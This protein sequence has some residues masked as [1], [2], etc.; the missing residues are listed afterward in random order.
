MT[1][2]ASRMTLVVRNP[3]HLMHGCTA[4]RQFDH[5]GGSIGST[6]CDWLLD[7]R[8]HAIHPLHCEIRLVEG[9]FCV[10]DLC[11]QTRLNGHDLA[12]GR[13]TTVKLNDG[14]SLHVGA[15]TLNV[16]LQQDR[17]GTDDLAH[18]YLS[19]HA[20]S[21]LF[22]ESRCPLE[23]LLEGHQ[24]VPEPDADT[25]AHSPEFER[26]STPLGLHEQ[27]DPL[28]ALDATQP[29]CAP[30]E[31]TLATFEHAPHVPPISCR[32]TAG[33]APMTPQPVSPVPPSARHPVVVARTLTLILACLLLGGCTMLGKLGHVIMNPSTPVGGPDDQPSL[34]ALS[35]YATNT[36]NPNAGSVRNI[37][38]G[39]PE[40]P[41]VQKPSGYTVNLNASNPLEL[42]DKLQALLDHLY[43]TPPAYSA[44]TPT[45]NATAMSPLERYVLGD[46]TDLQIGFTTPSQQVSTAPTP[47]DIATPIAFKIVQLKDDSLLRNA[48]LEAL[49]QDL[50]L[51]LG[52][53]YIDADDYVL[54]PGQFKFINYQPLDKK[55]RYL[56]VIARYHEANSTHWKQILRIQPKGHQYAL[57]VHLDSA[58]VEFKDETP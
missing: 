58:R 49:T 24:P 53:T 51:A 45:A 10:I 1:P 7:D 14:D 6:A 34:I 17:A 32:L 38:T 13:N 36:V 19:Q 39:G 33:D 16:Y 12:I 29:V 18:R 57:L 30:T 47:A 2:S 8:Q 5:A 46:Y 55:T 21:A 41:M 37:P 15:Y 25:P 9:R 3:E 35:L 27:H 23:T 28:R 20:V 52:S 48:N 40:G 31:L 4:N 50:Q 11:G 56:A 42:T 54:L 22:N 26:L 44:Q 43:T